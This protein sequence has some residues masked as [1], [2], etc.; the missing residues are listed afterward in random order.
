MKPLPLLLITGSLALFAAGCGGDDDKD[1]E[2]A[3]RGYDET[4]QALN[5]I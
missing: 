2:S 3:A 1:T 4:G 5:D